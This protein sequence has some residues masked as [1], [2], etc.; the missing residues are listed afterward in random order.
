MSVS[1]LTQPISTSLYFS[2]YES[3]TMLL[4]EFFSQSRQN[5]SIY[6]SVFTGLCVNT[7]TNP[8]WVL[9]YRIQSAQEKTP[10]TN[11]VKSIY[12]SNGTK[13]FFKGLGASYLGLSHRLIYYPCYEF[14]KE[15]FIG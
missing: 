13:G 10:V 12:R 11:L 2:L 7:L 5:I 15:M 14:L 8:L 1:M 3:S 9:K 6:S 4:S